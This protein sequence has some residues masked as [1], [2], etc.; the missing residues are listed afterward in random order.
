MLNMKKVQVINLLRHNLVYS[1][2]YLLTATRGMF[3]LFENFSDLII[4]IGSIGPSP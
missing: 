4:I 1:T 2:L 3:V